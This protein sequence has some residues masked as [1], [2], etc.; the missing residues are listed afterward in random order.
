[1]KCEIQH[2]VAGPA[3]RRLHEQ[4]GFGVPVEEIG[5]L[6]QIGD[7]VARLNLARL[8]R[9]RAASAGRSWLVLRTIGHD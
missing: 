8:R 1:M 3:G 7:D 4:Q 2:S 6:A 5:M 9:Q